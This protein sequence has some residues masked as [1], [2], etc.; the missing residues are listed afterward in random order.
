MDN[1]KNKYIGCILFVFAV[2]LIV[3]FAIQSMR[4]PDKEYLAYQSSIDEVIKNAEIANS[5]AEAANDKAEAVFSSIDED[6][7]SIVGI[8]NRYYDLSQK[9]QLSDGDK[10]LLAIYYENLSDYGV[11]LAGKANDATK[12]FQG[13]KKELEDLLIAQFKTKYVQAAKVLMPEAI[14]IKQNLQDALDDAES[15]LSDLQSESEK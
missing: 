4:K 7:I 9:A 10:D 14:Q 13:S 12:V 1:I 8:A 11:I 6:F 2:V 3:N 15:A 5:Q